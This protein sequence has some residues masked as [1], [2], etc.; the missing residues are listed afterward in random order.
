MGTGA[1]GR[2][3]AHHA[4]ASEHSKMR[5][6]RPG[7]AELIAAGG[8]AVLLALGAL[9]VGSRGTPPPASPETLDHISTKNR[10]AAATAAAHMKAESKEATRAADARLGAEAGEGEAR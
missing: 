4:L 3:W 6:R 8:L 7:R 2:H 1:R 5:R 10:E 9:V